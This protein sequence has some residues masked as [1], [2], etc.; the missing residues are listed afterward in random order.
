LD[1]FRIADQLVLEVYR[2]TANFP[3]AERYG[4]QAQVRRA[5]VSVG[6]NLVEGCQRPTTKDYLR[7]V[8]ISLGSASEARY[9]L[10]LASR[11]GFLPD[12]EQASL[13]PRYHRL[14]RSLERLVDSLQRRM[15]ISASL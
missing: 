9:L 5:A 2:A 4:M 15:G 1:V 12:A 3:V 13:E 10:D 14:V 7:F 6:T 11:L 8:A